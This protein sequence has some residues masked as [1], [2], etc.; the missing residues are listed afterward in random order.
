MSD[1]LLTLNQRYTMGIESGSTVIVD[2]TDG[3]EGKQIFR[4]NIWCS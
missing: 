1:V 4:N 2:S 3:A